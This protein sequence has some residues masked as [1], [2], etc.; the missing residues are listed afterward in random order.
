M[1]DTRI[2]AQRIKNHW[3]YCKWKYL[4]MVVLTVFGVNLIFTMTAYRAPEERK[5]EVYLC[6][7]YADTSLMMDELMPKLQAISPDQE[8]LLVT[9]INLLSE[10]M[11]ATMQFST[12][13]GAHQG[14]VLLLPRSEV[15]RYVQEEP[16]EMFVDL[17]P[18][19]E[20]GAINVDGLDM[21][22]VT[23]KSE[24]LGK[25]GVVGIPTDHL[26]GLCQYGMDPAGGVLVVTSYS[27]NE[28]NAVSMVNILMEYFAAEKPKGY[29]EWHKKMQE[30]TSSGMMV[31]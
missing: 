7:G 25:T 10:D 22:F 13:I 16:F 21:S 6:N 23:M 1:A 14:D 18:Y 17:T 8:E 27:G 15:M 3:V 9:N 12:Y 26:Y 20:S 31:F 29:D 30:S 28:E 11:Y 24:A 4:L 5:I 19:I 2:T